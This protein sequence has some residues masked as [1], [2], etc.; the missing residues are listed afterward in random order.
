MTRSER[1]RLS[2]EDIID[3]MRREVGERDRNARARAEARGKPPPRKS[4]VSRLV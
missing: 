1:F 3:R 4:R 2:N